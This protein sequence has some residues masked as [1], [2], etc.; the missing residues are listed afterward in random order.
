MVLIKK[1]GK[2]A[3]K[4]KTRKM[5][6]ILGNGKERILTVQDGQVIGKT[7][8]RRKIKTKMNVFDPLQKGK[9]LDF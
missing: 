2:M 8:V 1:R 9:L 7:I 4:K 5:R 3:R 6:Q